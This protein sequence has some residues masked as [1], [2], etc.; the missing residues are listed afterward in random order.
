[1]CREGPRTSVPEHARASRRFATSERRNR[2]GRRRDAPQ[3]S[4]GTAHQLRGRRQELDEIRRLLGT[5]RLLTLTGAGGCGKTRLALQVASELAGEFRDGIW[6]VDLGPVSE[7]GLVANSVSATVGIREGWYRPLTDSLGDYFRSRHALIVLDNCEH[8]ID[9]CAHLVEPLLRAAPHLRVLATSREGL[10][11]AGETVWRVPSMATPEA[12]RLFADRAVAVQPA[13]VVTDENAATVADI[14]RRL[15]GIPLAIELAAARLNVLSVDQVQARLS[16]RFRLLTGGSRT[17]IA[18]Q[19]TLEAT[20]DWSYDLLA[21]VERLLLCRLSVFPGGWTLEAAED[22]CGG[23]GLESEMMLDLLSRLVDKSL[24]NVEDGADG[25]RYRCLETVRQ[26]AR[27]RLLQ[28]GDAKRVRDRHSRFFLAFVRRAEPALVEADQALWLTRMQSEHDN[29]RSALEW[30]LDGHTGEDSGLE[31]A[32]AMSWFWIKR[33]HLGE[34]RVW[35]ERA[36]A[37]DGASS[38]LTAKA[39]A[40]LGS[41]TFFQGDYPTTKQVAERSLEIGR[42]VD[43]PAEAVLSL[44]LL[45]VLAFESGDVDRSVH[46]ARECLDAAATCGEPWRASPALQCLAY[47]AMQAGDFDE[48]CR[49]SQEALGHCRRKGD[50]WGIGM[51]LSDL[52]LFRVLQGHYT[53]AEHFCGEALAATRELGDRL[54]TAF[55]LSFLAGAQSGRAA[56]VGPRSCGERCTHCSTASGRLFNPHTRCGLA[57]ASSRRRKRR[58]ARARSTRRWRKAAPCRW[59]K[60]FNSLRALGHDSSSL[61]MAHS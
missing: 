42:A 41:I 8:L 24:V 14:C 55:F 60:P 31:M 53:E 10:G 26:Y 6:A 51:C 27:E 49:M 36:L 1:M 46:L 59:I 13:F 47:Q 38:R 21:E 19:R 61:L 5:S 15:D 25:S 12:R 7:P 11:I 17:A 23:S 50:T 18:R 37:N 48:A 22:V 16:D 32:A 44:G 3:Q 54:L 40:G 28:S 56:T 52:A 4:S 2:A 29:M 43:A 30:S 9:A 45:S 35:L 20:I 58:S 34:G 39:L 33:G 57:T